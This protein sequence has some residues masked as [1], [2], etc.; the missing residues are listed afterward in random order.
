MS[1]FGMNTTNGTQTE[2][3]TRKKT[4]KKNN[5]PSGGTQWPPDA[6]AVTVTLLSLHPSTR[7]VTVGVCVSA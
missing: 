4:N 6:E 2:V 7:V 3:A 5:N 1:T